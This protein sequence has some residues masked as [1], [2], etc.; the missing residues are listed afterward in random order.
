LNI[1]DAISSPFQKKKQTEI[2]QTASTTYISVKLAPEANSASFNCCSGT[3][4]MKDGNLRNK[5]PGC[6]ALM[7]VATLDA[8]VFILPPTKEKPLPNYGTPLYDL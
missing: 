1:L 3:N 2:P 4:R 5:I 8:R 6:N 7:I